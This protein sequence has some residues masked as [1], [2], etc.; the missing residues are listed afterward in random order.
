MKEIENTIL[1][2]FFTRGVGL[3]TW[4]DVGNIDRE[5]ALYKEL[6]VRLKRVNMVTYGGRKDKIYKEMLGDIKILPVTWHNQPITILQLLMK[7][8][9]E[10]KHSDILKTNQI[11][12]VEI[13]LW[14]KKRFGKKLIVRCGY[15]HSRHT[16][17][18][19][20]KGKIIR[21]AIQLEKLAFTS[22]DIGVV[23]SSWQRDVILKQ[24]K[25]DPTKIKTIPNYVIT[26]IF[27]P[28]SRI[29]K[30]YDLVF[31]GRGEKQKNIENLLKAL[32]YHKTKEHNISLMMVGKCCY[33]PNVTKL[34]T[35][36]GLDVTLR[37]TVPNFELPHVLKQSRLFILPSYY[38]GHPKVLLEAMSCGLPCIGTDVAGIR[39][40]IE[41]LVTGYLCKTDFESIADAIEVLLSDEVLQAKLGQNARKYILANYSLD[42]I[43]QLELDVIKEVLTS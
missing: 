23:S 18:K 19:H 12:G 22:A 2:L 35:E 20:N 16:I 24:Y 7:Y 34:I 3:R 9:P 10:I 42:K 8:Y 38:E 27:K 29:E 13:P 5:L 33:D 43:I 17:E 25:L 31:V 36:Y 1:T 6:A 37:G 26:D 40:D 28:D 32:H 15:L 30:N 41:H 39:E 21:A 14:F 11:K 4:V